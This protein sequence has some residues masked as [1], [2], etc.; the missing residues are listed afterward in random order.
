M[1]VK[2]LGRISYFYNIINYTPSTTNGSTA[3]GKRVGVSEA[4][5]ALEVANLFTVAEDAIPTPSSVLCA[6]HFAS[7][8]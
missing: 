8:I 6:L 5:R 1:N 2:N 7:Y 4:L 3:L